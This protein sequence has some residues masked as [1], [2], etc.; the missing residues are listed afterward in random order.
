MLTDAQ[1]TE[2][3][4]RAEAAT[5]GPWRSMRDGNQYIQIGIALVPQTLQGNREIFLPLVDGDPDC[6]EWVAQSSYH[7]MM[8]PAHRSAK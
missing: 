7:Y 8:R 5:P 6:N 4:K 2:I 1:L 3:E